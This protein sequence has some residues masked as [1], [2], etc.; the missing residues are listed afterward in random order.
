MK[1]LLITFL[2]CLSVLTTQAQNNVA[3]QLM[4]KEW[5][6]DQ[7]R[8]MLQAIDRPS[9]AMQAEVEVYF[10]PSEAL[11][12]FGSGYVNKTY[13]HVAAIETVWDKNEYLTDLRH[14]DQK[15]W[16]NVWRLD[17]SKQF[18]AADS[19]GRDFLIRFGRALDNPEQA[20]G[21]ATEGLKLFGAR[22]F[23]TV[24]KYKSWGGCKQNGVGKKMMANCYCSIGSSFNMQCENDCTSSQG[25]GCTTTDGQCGFLALYNCD[26]GCRRD[27]ENPIDPP[28]GE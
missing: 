5:T 10:T 14:R 19:E 16:A 7:E 15:E 1:T 6:T 8:L 12:V 2:F 28:E 3:F 22:P 21:Y 18:K 9:N 17:L 4:S 23:I 11:K 25:N 24:G 13:K 20:K 26:G 27:G